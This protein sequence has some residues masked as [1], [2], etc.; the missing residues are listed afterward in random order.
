MVVDGPLLFE[1]QDPC[2]IRETN[3]ESQGAWECIC[4]LLY[5]R[6]YIDI[7]INCFSVNRRAIRVWPISFNFGAVWASSC[8]NGYGRR[9]WR[10]E[11]SR[12]LRSCYWG[13][14][15]ADAYGVEQIVDISRY[16]GYI[17][18]GR[19]DFTMGSVYFPIFVFCYA[20]Y[21]RESV[22]IDA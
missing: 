19:E 22:N 16:R 18:S 2:S 15:W 3:W 7:F 9:R 17:N 8:C 11:A 1:A 6:I 5:M 20:S 12:R 13:R 21:Y 4:W 14:R 10:G